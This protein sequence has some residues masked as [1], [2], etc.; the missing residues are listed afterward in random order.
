MLEIIPNGK[1][2]TLLPIIRGKVDPSAVIYSDGWR[3]YDGLVDV[4]YDTYFRVN[5]G[6]NEF[7]KKAQACIS[8]GS[9]TSGVSPRDAYQKSS[10]A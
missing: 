8:M 5:R 3:G 4:E 1:Q 7:A 6:E 2:V 9:K 10:M